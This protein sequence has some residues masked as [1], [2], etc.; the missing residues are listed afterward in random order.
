MQWGFVIR[1]RRQTLI[2]ALLPKRHTAKLIT[3]KITFSLSRRGRGIASLML[4]WLFRSVVIELCRKVVLV[5]TFNKNNKIYVFQ[6]SLIEFWKVSVI[7]THCIMSVCYDM[8]I[9]MKFSILLLFDKSWWEEL[10][11]PVNLTLAAS[12]EWDQHTLN[13]KRST[14]TK[15]IR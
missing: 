1:V 12:S 14:H 8:L 5:F 2:S 7:S 4:S 3:K 11:A 15:L 6:L 13:V 10:L 9:S